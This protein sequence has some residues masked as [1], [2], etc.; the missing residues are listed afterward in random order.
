MCCHLF[1]CFD[2]DFDLIWNGM[3]SKESKT[4]VEWKYIVFSSSGLD[5]KDLLL[6]ELCFSF[7]GIFDVPFLFYVELEDDIIPSQLSYL[8]WSDF[9]LDT[10]LY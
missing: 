4:Y 10:S 9:P 1:Y 7:E 3:R 6:G 5:F 8:L 2:G